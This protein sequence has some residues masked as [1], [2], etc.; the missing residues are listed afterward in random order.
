MNKRTIIILVLCAAL[1]AAVAV[2]SLKKDPGITGLYL[3]TVPSLPT[4]S[5][6]SAMISPI[7]LSLFADIVATAAISERSE[8]F[9]LIFFS[10]AITV[11]TA[12]SI[13]RFSAIG[14]APWIAEGDSGFIRMKKEMEM[15][16]GIGCQRIAAPPAGLAG[17][18]PLD[19]LAAGKKYKRLLDLGRKIP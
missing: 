18:A 11:S 15:L 6:A 12:F 16:A 3:N 13:P 4:F 8:T 19:L 1:I 14:F 9:L 2:V 5:I 17:D 10:S 7:V